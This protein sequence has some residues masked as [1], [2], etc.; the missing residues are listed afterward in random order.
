[1]FELNIFEGKLKKKIL[2]M[3]FF[4]GFLPIVILSFLSFYSLKTFHQFDISSIEGNLINQKSGEIEGFVD[5]I[6]TTF[7]LQVG[8]E[9]TSDIELSGQHFLLERM[10]DL[11]SEVLEISFISINGQ[12]TSKIKRSSSEKILVEDLIDQS[13]TE[14]FKIARAGNNY[15]SPA[16]FTDKGP[17]VTI[18]SPVLN[19][20]NYIISILTGELKLDGLK[21]IIQRSHVGNSGYVYIVDSNGHLISH[22]QENKITSESL[23]NL[24][25]VS[26]VLNEKKQDKT[27]EKRYTSFWGE[28]VVSAGKYINALQM[29]VIIEWPVDD[30]DKV[31]NTLT[32]QSLIV[33]LIVLAATLF[34]SILMANR[35]VSPVKS[36]EKGTHLVA[37]GN[38]DQPMVIKTGDELEELGFAFNNMMVGLKKLKELEKEFVFIAA[39]DLRTPVTAIKGYLSLML[40][41]GYGEVTPNL[42]EALV[43]VTNA[44]QRLVQLVNDLLVVARAEAGRIPIKV[45]PIEIVESIRAVISELTP[46]ADEKKII[47]DYQTQNNLP[48]VLADPERVKEAMVNLVGNAIKY[49]LGSGSV[50]ISH[51]IKDNNLVTHIKDTGMGMSQEAQKKLFE[52]YYRVEN[53]KTKDIQGTGLGLFIVKQLI[54]KMNGS[55]WVVSEEGKGSTFSFSLPLA[56]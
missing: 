34:S 20:N 6:I 54:E 16:Y 17:M 2:R 7:Q 39:H 51:E 33:S 42:K 27:F 8:F 4:V 18:A 37:E 14:K 22:S 38:L 50:A 9:Q 26:S 3:M 15:I 40:D 21:K 52:K 30:A 31:V 47:I 12:E 46:L 55:I 10:L 45:S 13:Q 1:M 35:I 23:K 11:N 56:T 24:S 29:A 19:K 5:D 49:T 53:D 25:F 44:N 28:K 48:K 43:K 32:W 36:L 41:G